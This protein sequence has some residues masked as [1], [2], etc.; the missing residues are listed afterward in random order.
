MNKLCLHVKT[1]FGKVLSN[2]P[3]RC[4]HKVTAVTLCRMDVLS[5]LQAH[6][7][8]RIRREWDFRER[9]N[10]IVYEHLQV[11]Q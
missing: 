6:K 3:A 4:T 2:Q 7:N 8:E 5:F 9:K 11:W 1:I 10:F